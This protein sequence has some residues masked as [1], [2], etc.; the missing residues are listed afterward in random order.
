M[1]KAL[2]GISVPLFCLFAIFIVSTVVPAE[3]VAAHYKQG[4]G[5]S[6]LKLLGEDGKT[7]A[8]GEDLTTV[9]G[10]RVTS[11]LT[12]RFRDGSID[13]DTTVFDQRHDLRVISDHHLQKGSSFPHP[14]D[15]RI[16]VPSAQ[17]TIHD[18]KSGKET[19][20]H[21]DLPSDVGNGVVLNFI[22][23][24]PAGVSQT[25]M[26]YV[27]VGSKARLVKLVISAAG[28]DIFSIA[29][30]R[31]RARKY[32]IKVELGGLAAVMAPILG[33]QP[34]PGCIWLMDD[35]VPAFLKMQTP[36]YEGGPVWTIQ[37]ASPVWTV[38]ASNSGP[39]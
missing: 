32:E 1:R 34:K 39:Q 21:V 25:T 17:V 24:L 16:D 2:S 15:V 35:K 27:T 9:H 31:H 18:L 37:Q 29:G 28:R 36:L 7:L 14:L 6:F 19:S 13:D 5:H 22:E 30:T 12:F 26:S 4:C 10:S 38:Q 33:K 20:E 8:V 23:N 11:R 3:P